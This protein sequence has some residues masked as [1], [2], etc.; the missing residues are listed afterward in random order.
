MEGCARSFGL[1]NVDLRPISLVNGARSDAEGLKQKTGALALCSSGCWHIFG[2]DELEA[3][4]EPGYLLGGR[5]DLRRVA[6]AP[7]HVVS[8]V[9][10][11]FLRRHREYDHSQPVE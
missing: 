11:L 2:C 4:C 5:S 3:L 10:K 8:I 6:V 1:V 9:G 7:I